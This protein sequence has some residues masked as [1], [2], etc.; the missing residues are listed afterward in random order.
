MHKVDGFVVAATTKGREREKG[1]T[2]FFVCGEDGGCGN[3]SLL[4]DFNELIVIGVFA[5]GHIGEKVDFAVTLH[6][7]KTGES[8]I[9]FRR[10]RN[11]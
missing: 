7:G 4:D 1:D 2:G 11:A 3:I 9:W 10:N 5:S 8:V 6:D